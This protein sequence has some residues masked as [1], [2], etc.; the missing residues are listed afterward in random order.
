MSKQKIRIIFISLFG[1][2][3][4]GLGIYLSKEIDNR[5]LEKKRH[6]VMRTVVSKLLTGP[7]QELITLYDEMFQQIVSG[8]DQ[9]QG[10][11][12]QDSG[13]YIPDSSKLENKLREMYQPY[14]TEESYEKFE[15]Q[16]LN[17]F[18]TYSTTNGYQVIVH[19]IDITQSETIP[20]NYS[21]MADMRYG[22]EGEVLKPIEVTGSIQ[23]DHEEGKLTYIQFLNQDLF[24][25]LRN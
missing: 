17:E 9:Q 24:K 7:N 21:F 5:N 10:T 22:I 6:D 8:P 1:I 12:T 3:I 14:F 20:T 4:I 25:T 13:I 15:M 2:V 23:M 11:S 16:F 19:D 18:H